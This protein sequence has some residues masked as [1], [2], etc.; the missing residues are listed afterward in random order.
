MSGLSLAAG[1]SGA[2]RLRF[3]DTNP[4]DLTPPPTLT[5]AVHLDNIAITVVESDADPL[6]DFDGNGVV[7]CADLDGYIG[8]IGISVAD[9]TG[10]LANLD[11]D[12]D[13]T[14][15]EADAD[16]VIRNLVVTS[17]GFT[18]TFLGDF[19]CDGTVDV[20]NDAFALVGNLGGSAVSY[21]EGDA[22]FDGIIDV[23][24]DAFTLVGNLGN[25]NE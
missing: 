25:T 3:F 17:N 12:L 2:F 18:G 7:D 15:S 6:G 1:E 24:N 16:M 19:N 21:S 8:N 23:L 20:L 14:I 11:F 4:N 5:A 13:D 9:V 10:G 22:N